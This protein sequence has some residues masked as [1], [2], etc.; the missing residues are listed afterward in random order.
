MVNTA[1]LRTDAAY[2][3]QILRDYATEG[4]TAHFRP[5]AQWGAYTY[6]QLGDL[7]L[8]EATQRLAVLDLTA[9]PEVARFSRS[10][11]EQGWDRASTLAQRDTVLVFL[12]DEGRITVLLE[13]GRERRVA[14]AVLTVRV[15]PGTT[16]DD[17][18]TRAAL[19]DELEVHVDHGGRLLGW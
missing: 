13:D 5:L 12:P 2:R 7:R 14:E 11:P 1:R 19:L 4:I 8:T 9:L 3:G 15:I 10:I 17:A 16:E 6:V 18:A